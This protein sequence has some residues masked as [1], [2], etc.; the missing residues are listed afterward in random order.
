[1]SEKIRKDYDK[2]E[3]NERI[4]MKCDPGTHSQHIKS[5]SDHERIAKNA[6]RMVARA[7]KYE[8]DSQRNNL[9]SKASYT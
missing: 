8:V 5:A 7:V 9:T 3:E 6:L 1:M 2:I 4:S